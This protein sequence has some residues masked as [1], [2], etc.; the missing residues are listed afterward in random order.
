QQRENQKK[1]GGYDTGLKY[2]GN[3]VVKNE[4]C[5]LQKTSLSKAF[6][7]YSSLSSLGCKLFFPFSSQLSTSNKKS[8]FYYYY[9]GIKLNFML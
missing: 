5:K 1:G 6:S 7:T 2:T 8:F 3:Q 9:P 4:F